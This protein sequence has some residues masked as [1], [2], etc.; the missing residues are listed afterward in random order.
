MTYHK[1]DIVSIEAEVEFDQAPEDERIYLKV[2]HSNTSVTPGKARL[3]RP[4][5]KPGELIT[6]STGGP[7]ASVVAVHEGFAW[8]KCPTGKMITIA[9]SDAVRVDEDN[10]PVSLAQKAYGEAAE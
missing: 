8:A 10:S 7:K 5:L 9:L 4:C 3:V 2:G 1:G 6:S